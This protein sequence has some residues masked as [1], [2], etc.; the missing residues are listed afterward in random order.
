MAV[1]YYPKDSVLYKRT[2]TIGNLEELTLDVP[3]NA[4]FLFSG[5][6]EFSASLSVDSAS[7][8][9]SSV[10]SSY[11]D[12]SNISMMSFVADVALLADTASISAL[13]DTASYAYQS[14]SASWAP[15]T[16]QDSSLSASWASQSLSA[17]WAPSMGGLAGGI[18]ITNI[19]PQNV[20]DN[21]SDKIYS[22]NG[23]VLE[24]CLSNTDLVIVS[25]IAIVGHTNFIPNA[26]LNGI[27]IILSGSV[28]SAVLTGSLIMDTL[29]NTD[30]TVLHE[31]GAT[32]TTTVTYDVGPTITTCEFTG[33]YPSSQTELKANDVFNLHVITDIP[34]SKIYVY[35]EEA[36]IFQTFSFA[37]VI[38]KVV[39]VVIADRGTITQ[40]LRAHVKC[41]NISGSYGNTVYSNNTVDLNNTYPLINIG[42]I[43]YPLGQ[44]ALKNSESA[45]VLNAVTSFNTILYSSGNGDLN[46]SNATTYE[47]NKIVT[48]VGGSYNVSINNFSISATRTA[49]NAIST[50]SGL[51]KIAD[52]LPTIT[53]SV[54]YARLRSGG[55]DGTSAQDY[56]VTISSNQLLLSSPTPSL[57]LGSGGGTWQGSGFTGAGATWTRTVRINDN[58]IKGNY[59]FI[60]LLVYNLANIQQT[61]IG[62]GVTYVL[63]GFVIRTLYLEAFENTTVMNVAAVTYPSKVNMFWTVKSLPTKSSVGTTAPPP[64][65]GAWSISALNTNPTTITILDTQATDASSQQTT[66]TIEETV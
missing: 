4:V 15:G 55:N 29:H 12:T 59:S 2:T 61:T 33:S 1:V 19:V 60:N 36:C 10:S 38:D 34:M 24:S 63:G 31:D 65:A 52:T 39:S 27:P 11:A 62:S 56:V 7:W 23:I 13:A 22:S 40:A 64:I 48:R 9:S 57:D 37:P 5:S 25:V 8:A 14:L 26:T 54:P 45:S 46:I 21:V 66:L 30:L 32:H 17:S 58:M 44:G 20:G 41:M 3:P 6:S 51:V 28:S 18:F 50:N 42:T 53:V 43:T 16:G 49:N 47:A 35:N